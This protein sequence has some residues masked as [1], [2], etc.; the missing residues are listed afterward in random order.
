[1]PVDLGAKGSCHIGG[2]VATNAGGLRLLRY[3]SLH[4][5]VLGLEVVLPD[6]T[7]L[8]QLSTLRKDNTGY[9]LKQLFIGAEGT[10]GIITAVSIL[11]PPAPAVSIII[12]LQK[13]SG[14]DPP[15]S[16]PITSC[17]PFPPSTISSQCSKRPNATSPKS[18]PH[19]STSIV[20]LTTS[21][22][23]TDKARAWMQ[24]TSRVSRRSSS[25][26]RVVGRRNMTKRYVFPPT[27]LCADRT[28][29]PTLRN[30]TASSRASWEATSHS[31]RLV[32]WLNRETN[33]SSCG[34]CE[35]GSPRPCRKRGR[36][37]NTTLV[38]PFRPSRRLWIRFKKG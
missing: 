8:D 9:D 22:P 37:T 25:L 30:S 17:S 10:L 14:T 36:Y 31:S 11:T 15:P 38:S 35:R 18:S 13:R 33:L 12:F 20:P 24:A 29:Q 32:F 23:S 6:G 3:G 19:L 4:G 28:A 34:V 16:R 1:M 2:N 7:V 26:R 5:T 27:Y 21:Q